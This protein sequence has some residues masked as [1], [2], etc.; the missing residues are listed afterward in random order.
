MFLNI[1]KDDFDEGSHRR[2]I[3]DEFWFNGLGDAHCKEEGKTI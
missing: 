2:Q 1:F 3:Y